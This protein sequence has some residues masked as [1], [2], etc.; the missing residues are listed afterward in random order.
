MVSLFRRLVVGL[1]PDDLVFTSPSGLPWNSDNFRRRYWRPAVAAAIACPCHPNVSVGRAAGTQ[2]VP[3]AGTACRCPDR[4][5][6]TLRLQDLRHTHVGYLIDA[7]WDFH[8]I[9]LRLG[10]ASIKTT[11]DIYGHRLPHGDQPGLRALD[12]RLPGGN[13]DSAQ[14]SRQMW[15]GNQHAVLATRQGSKVPVDTRTAAA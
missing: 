13:R 9:Q 4:L 1:R 7:G 5:H 2:A 10:H 3:V 11:F 8:A 14:E 12:Q 6:Q 15:S